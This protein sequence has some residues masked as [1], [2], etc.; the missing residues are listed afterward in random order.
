MFRAQANNAQLLAWQGDFDGAKA[1][2]AEVRRRCEVRGAESDLMFVYTQTALIEIWSGDYAEAAAVADE[3]LERAEQLGG[4]NSILGA[5][6]VQTAVAAYTG[7]EQLA[8]Q[9]STRAMDTAARC[10]AHRTAEVTTM[11]LAFLE[12]SLGRHAEALGVL[13]GIL[14][15]FSAIADG[16]GN[17]LR[18]VHSRRR[19]IAGDP[20]QGGRRRTPGRRAGG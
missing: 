9:M 18:D 6:T 3:A 14:A 10:G 16:Y 8:R 12:V 5:L 7:R 15:A 13:D 4:D 19:G 2:M 20:G 17:H 1:Q 11:M